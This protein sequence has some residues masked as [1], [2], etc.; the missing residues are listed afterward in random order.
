MGSANQKNHENNVGHH[1]QAHKM[2]I[3]QRSTAKNAVHLRHMVHS[4]TWGTSRCMHGRLSQSHRT[5]NHNSKSGCPGNHWRAKYLANRHARHTHTFAPSS[6][7][8]Q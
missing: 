6:A 5:N 1:T 4:N 2:T 8:S 7:N 3:H